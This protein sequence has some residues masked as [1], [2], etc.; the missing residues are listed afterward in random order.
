M[1]FLTGEPGHAGKRN[2]SS[3][4]TLIEL[5]MVMVLL[6]II[7][8][9]GGKFISQSFQGFADTQT[10]T[11]MYEEGKTALIRLEREIHVAIPNAISVS[12]SN[13]ETISF[14]LIDET[15]MENIFGQYTDADPTG[16]T[17]ITDQTAAAASGSL[18]SIYNT[19]WSNFTD[20]SRVYAITGL[21]GG[22]TMNLDSAIEPASPYNRYFVV[23]DKA[24]QFVVSGTT[25]SRQT[26]TVTSGTVGSFASPKPL[27][28]DIYQTDSLPF[29]NY[30]I[31]SST[32]SSSIAVHF[33]ISRG[34]ESINFHKEI[35]VHNVP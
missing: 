34:G 11:E 20:G 31:S 12:G 10:R 23:R 1:Q 16:T 13:G 17:A 5:I 14:G 19:S 33:T 21:P 9:M 29:F 15:A 27:V 2:S 4:F 32:K 22:N 7:G 3:G 18:I 28:K 24:V 6:S 26:A 35:L 25:L 30:I 8:V